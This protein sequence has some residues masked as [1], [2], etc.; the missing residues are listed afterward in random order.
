MLATYSQVRRVLAM[1]CI[2]LWARLAHL[3][4]VWKYIQ[5]V[6]LVR[7]FSVSNK[8]FMLRILLTYF[9]FLQNSSFTALLGHGMGRLSACSLSFRKGATHYRRSWTTHKRISIDLHWNITMVVW[10]WFRY[11]L[12]ELKGSCETLVCK[13]STTHFQPSVW[14]FQIPE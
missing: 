10:P 5:L 8:Y 4:I 11:T 7:I 9:I 3:H 13:I 14:L 2:V 12:A 6:Y 1:Y